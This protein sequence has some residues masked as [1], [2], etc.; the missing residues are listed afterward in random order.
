MKGK[1]FGLIV[2]T[3][4]MFGILL[5]PTG[6]QGAVSVGTDVA[7]DDSSLRWDQSTVIRWNTTISSGGWGYYNGTIFV[8]LTA[9]SATV[10]AYTSTIVLSDTVSDDW[11]NFSFDPSEGGTWSITAEAGCTDGD[12]NITVPDAS[13]TF[14]VESQGTAMGRMITELAGTM[15]LIVFVG[16][17]LILLVIMLNRMGK[18]GGKD[19]GKKT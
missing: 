1:R 16:I 8:N 9:P 5:S 11:Y 14:T 12:A 18:T 13:N 6:V 10:H 15:V 2:A 19:G 4:A 17:L 3:I 7:A